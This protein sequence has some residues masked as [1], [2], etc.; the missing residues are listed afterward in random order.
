MQARRLGK[1][2]QWKEGLALAIHGL[3]RGRQWSKIP[4]MKSR[5]RTYIFCTYAYNNILQ[6]LE[7]KQWNSR[8]LSHS[9]S[10]RH[11]SRQRLWGDSMSA[12][13]PFAEISPVALSLIRSFSLD[14]SLPAAS[15][16]IYPT[17]ISTLRFPRRY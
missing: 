3:D 14:L 13:Q 4:N 9:H 8:I 6:Q 10:F 11:T 15:T 5:P 16:F 17:S 12:V 1:H 2:G 7:I